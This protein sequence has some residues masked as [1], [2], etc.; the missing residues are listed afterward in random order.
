[1][2]ETAEVYTDGRAMNNQKFC[3]IACVNDEVFFEECKLYLSRLYIPEGY[4]VDILTIVDAK[5]MTAGYNEAMRASDAKYKIYL[6]QDTFITDRYFLYELLQIFRTNDKIGMVGAVG[7]KE[8][9]KDGVMWHGYRVG[10]FYHDQCQRIDLC[11]NFEEVTD[12]FAVEAIDGMLMATQYDI[13]WREDLFRQFDYYDVSQSMEFL[14]AGYI[15]LVPNLP[16]PLCVHDD[17]S[18]LDLQNYDDNRRIFL[19]EYGD[20]LSGLHKKK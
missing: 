18:I 12:V 11:E 9:S 8:L 2:G 1:M 15:I 5:S 3:F 16:K 13:P 7:T 20:F 19:R 17:G 4:D 14:R 10:C 6:H